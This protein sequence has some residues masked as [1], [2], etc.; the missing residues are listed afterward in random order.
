MTER[1]AGADFDSVE[2]GIVD[3]AILKGELLGTRTAPPRV[4]TPEDSPVALST[5]KVRPLMRYPVAALPTASY[6]SS[7]TFG[8]LTEIWPEVGMAPLLR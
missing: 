7:P 4:E 6:I 2:I 8:L 1:A 3:V 5:E